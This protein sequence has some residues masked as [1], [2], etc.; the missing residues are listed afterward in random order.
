MVRSANSTRTSATLSPRWRAMPPATPAASLPSVQR[1]SGGRVRPPGVDASSPVTR[2]ASHPRRVPALTIGPGE[3][4]GGGPGPEPG[5][6]LMCGRAAQPHRRGMTET[7]A[8]P[9][10]DPPTDNPMFIRPREG[11]MIAGVCTGIAQR[12]NLDLTLVRIVTVVLTLFTGVALAAYIGAWLLTPSTDAPAPLT[13]DSKTAKWASRNGDRLMRR[14]PAIVLIV[15]A[16]IVLSGLAHALWFGAPVGFLVAVLLLAIVVGTKRGRWVLVTVAALLAVGLAT[17]GVFGAHL[18]TRTYT[19]ATVDDLHDHYDFGAGKVN[20]DLS[21]LTALSGRY[22]TDVRLGRG[23]VTVVVPQG[24]PV[25]VHGQS[26]LGSVVID[27]HKG[28]G[29]DAEQPRAATAGV[30]TSEDRLF[31]DVVVGVGKVTVRT[32]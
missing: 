32:A 28:S 25:V 27:G 17:V 6:R 2:P 18:G 23:D 14:G 31:V 3:T 5:R 1:T 29:V 24:V 21:A 4:R 30:V 8:N 11:R 20:L 22:R 13:A 19:V 12:W 9:P 7:A 16:A 15:L 26:G 10:L